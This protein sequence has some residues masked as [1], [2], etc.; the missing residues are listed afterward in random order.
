M[1]Q[2]SSELEDYLSGKIRLTDEEQQYADGLVWELRDEWLYRWHRTWERG[3]VSEIL[4][5]GKSLQHLGT[6]RK[7][8]LLKLYGEALERKVVSFSISDFECCLG[9]YPRLIRALG[10]KFEE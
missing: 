4:Q 1:K 2:I 6:S 9:A 10:G 7:V 5:F 3:L 8:P